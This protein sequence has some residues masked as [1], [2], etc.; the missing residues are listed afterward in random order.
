MSKVSNVIDMLMLLNTGRKYSIKELS[1]KLEV[2]PRMIRVYKEDLDKA[3]IF[4]D[5]IRG[6]YGGY[7]LNRKVVIPERDYNK[8]KIKMSKLEKKIYNT[9]TKALNEKRKVKL[10]YNSNGDI[11][12][13]IIHPMD[14]YLYNDLWYIPAYCEYRKSMRH[15][16]FKYILE[17][18]LLNEFYE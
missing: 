1:E 7:I 10:L 18:E 9:I 3:G 4:I 15:F 16:L 14:M 12:Q 17:I 2:T 6:P 8:E 13:R 11:R 5:T